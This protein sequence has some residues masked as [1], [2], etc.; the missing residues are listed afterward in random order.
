MVA[1]FDSQMS[2]WHSTTVCWMKKKKWKEQENTIKPEERSAHSKGGGVGHQN[3]LFNQCNK[4][5]LV[6]SYQQFNLTHFKETSCWQ[7]LKRYL[8]IALILIP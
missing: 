1:M 5:W 7:L 2:K 4:D 6:H 8:E 3:S